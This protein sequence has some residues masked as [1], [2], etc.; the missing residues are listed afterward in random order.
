[1]PAASCLIRRVVMAAGK[2]RCGYTCH[3][4]DADGFIFDLDFILRRI[5]GVN[6]TA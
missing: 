2:G 6:S 1:M 3:K 5:G 4:I